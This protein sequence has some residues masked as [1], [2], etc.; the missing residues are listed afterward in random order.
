VSGPAITVKDVWRGALPP[1]TDLLGGGSGLERRV[2]WA[3]ALRTRAPAFDAVKGGEIAF[4]PVRSIRLLDERLD[5]PQVMSSFAEKGGVAVAVLG[6][7]SAESIDIADRLVMPLLRLPDSVHLADAHHA[8]VRFILDQRTLLHER[9]QELQLTLMQM[10]LSGAGPAA[11]IDELAQLTSLTAA[12]LDHQGAVRHTAGGDAEQTALLVDGEAAALRR[13]GDT[14]AVLVADPPVREFPANGSALSMLAS[15]IPGRH[16]VGGFIAVI[17]A[18]PELDQLAR[19]AV[20]RAASACAIELD[21]ERAVVETRDR[22]E[23]EFI[24]SLLGGSYSS[25]EVVGERARRLGVDLDRNYAVIAVRGARVA[26]AAWEDAALR[27]ARTLIAHREMEA[28]V[29]VHD[30]GVCAVLMLD[31]TEDASLGRLVEAIRAECARITDDAG[32]SLGIGRPHTGAAGVRASFREAEQALAMGR[33]VLGPGRCVSFADLGLHRLL[34][35]MAQHAELTDF[36]EDAVGLLVAYDKRSGGDLMTTLD[37]FFACHG[38]PTETAQRLRLHRNTVLYRLRRIEE[39]GGLRLD[40]AATRLNLHL[41]LRIRD[42]L[43]ASA[44]RVGPPRP[45]P[46]SRG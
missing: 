13:W 39:I 8:C 23:G 33:R 6:D 22:L 27:G 14:V 24:D 31:D 41:C 21:R 12:W 42:V 2:E 3:C 44:P 18:E 17:G 38:S 35:A 40:D 32:T 5:L 28:L 46:V 15:P 7:V 26:D 25:E 16:G 36:Y 9:A 19:L 1:G 20:A 29:G 4:V 34:F 43:Q 45:S 11:I 30:G 10:A 37:A